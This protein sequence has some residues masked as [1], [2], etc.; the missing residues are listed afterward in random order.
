MDRLEAAAKT[1]VHTPER[2]RGLDELGGGPYP[3]LSVPPWRIVY[4]IA[5]QEVHVLGVFDGRHD[6]AEHFRERLLYR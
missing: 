6:L 1:L 4:A 5:K 3:Q 2:G